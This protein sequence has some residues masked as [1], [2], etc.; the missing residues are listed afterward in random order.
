V[1]HRAHTAGNRARSDGLGLLV[2]C[3]T[4][5]LLARRLVEP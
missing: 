3:K 2:T 1:H 5:A 4:T